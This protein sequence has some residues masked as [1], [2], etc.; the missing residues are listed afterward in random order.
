MWPFKKRLKMTSKVCNEDLSHTL[1]T[2][3]YAFIDTDVASNRANNNPTQTRAEDTNNNG[4]FV[5]A[6]DYS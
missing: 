5:S 3:F 6:V 2:P 1:L 4:Y